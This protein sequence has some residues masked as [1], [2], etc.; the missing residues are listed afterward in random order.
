MDATTFS[1]SGARDETA[2]LLSSHGIPY[3][4][5]GQQGSE[6]VVIPLDSADTNSLRALGFRLGHGQGAIRYLLYFRGKFCG[7]VMEKS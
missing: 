3:R 4:R 7:V 2:H 6:R 5:I 1:D